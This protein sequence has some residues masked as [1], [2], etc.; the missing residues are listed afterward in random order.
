MS[1]EIAFG[2]QIRRSIL[3]AQ[4]EYNVADCVCRDT[5]CDDTDLGGCL[6][7]L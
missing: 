1:F 3:G 5:L 7:G 6:R 2:M 4:R